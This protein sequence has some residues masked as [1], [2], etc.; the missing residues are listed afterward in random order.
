[1]RAEILTNDDHD[2]LDVALGKLLV[3]YEKGYA[4]KKMLLP[5]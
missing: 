5:L 1:M 4:K 3:S 2:K